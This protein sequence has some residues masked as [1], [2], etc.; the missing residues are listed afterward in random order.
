MPLERDG[1]FILERIHLKTYTPDQLRKMMDVVPEGTS[2]ERFQAVLGSGLVTDIFHADAQIANRLAVR[3]ALGLGALPSTPGSHIVDY[4]MTLEQMIAA[5]NY[6]WKNDDITAKWFPIVGKG[7]VEFEDTIFHF[8][9]DISSE[10]AV[11]EILAADTKN[12]WEPGRIEN[13]LAYGAKNPE[14]QRKFPIVGLG[15][16]GEVGGLRYVPC[17]SRYD[18][19]RRLDLR[20]WVDAGG[21]RCRF[22]GVRKKVSQT[23]NS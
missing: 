12:P 22:L 11:K 14:E 10:D 16:V 6:D 8:D 17:L 7:K 23:S 20:W 9:H 5:G 21:A 3:R 4:D 2:L 18:S 19:R 1:E 13:I 15:S